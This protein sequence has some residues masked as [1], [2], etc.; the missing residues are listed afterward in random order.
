M[1]VC[2]NTDVLVNGPEFESTPDISRAAE[3]P[4]VTLVSSKLR[5]SSSAM[6]QCVILAPLAG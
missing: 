6:E 5:Y 3:R 1:L 2:T 4:G